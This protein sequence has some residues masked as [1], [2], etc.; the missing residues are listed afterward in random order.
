[1]GDKAIILKKLRQIA[2]ETNNTKLLEKLVD[3]DFVSSLNKVSSTAN[4]LGFNLVVKEKRNNFYE[5]INSKISQALMLSYIS[6]YF[7]NVIT[8]EYIG[9]SGS[10]SYNMLKIQESGTDFFV[11]AQ[12]NIDKIIYKDDRERVH[13]ALKREVFIGDIQNNEQYVVNYRLLLNGTP[14]YV[15][16][17]AI[18]LAEDDNNIIVGVRNIDEQTKQEQEIDRKLKQNITYT[19]IALALA[20]NFFTIYYVNVETDEYVEYNLD[21]EKQKLQKVSSGSKFFDDSIVNAKRLIV[22]EDLDKFLKA[23]DKNNLLNALKEKKTFRLSYRQ[24]FNNVPTWVSLIVVTLIHDSTHILF[25][26]SN[27]DD[28]KK[29][30]LELL[31]EKSFARTDALTGVNNKFSYVEIEDKYN[32]KIKNKE[33]TSFAVAVCDIN[34]LKLIND[35]LGHSEGDKYIIDARDTIKSVFKNSKIYRIGGD[36]F[37]LILEGEDF[38]NRNKLLEEFKALNEKNQNTNKAVVACGISDFNPEYDYTLQDIFNRADKAMYKN[39][40]ILKNRG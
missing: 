21:T 9:Y 25:G 19:N 29:K 11:D 24:L 30:E 15:S 3:D 33:I 20:K 38:I 22:P 2:N 27:I 31:K 12:E 26:I 36:E 17:K 34:N 16:L 5:E 8:G 35:T 39:K 32:L 7:V 13:E 40:E 23:I 4:K 10:K 6:I 18:R 28:Q 14:T 37:V 1:M